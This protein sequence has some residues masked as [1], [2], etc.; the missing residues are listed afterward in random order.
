MQNHCVL[1][2]LNATRTGVD[3]LS[4]KSR[5]FVKHSRASVFDGGPEG[6]A[7]P[8]RTY[9]EPVVTT[10]LPWYGRTFASFTIYG[11]ISVARIPE[12]FALLRM[13]LQ[14]EWS[15]SGGFVSQFLIKFIYSRLIRCLVQSS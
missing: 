2:D 3:R 14:Q 5:N 11:E 6:M 12:E 1:I 10:T 15:F 13:R 4:L 8:S 9:E 7:V